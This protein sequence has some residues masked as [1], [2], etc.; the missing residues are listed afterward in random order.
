MKCT[1]ISYVEKFFSDGRESQVL[2]VKSRDP[3]AV[4]CNSKVNGFRFF[5]V[6]EISENGS[7]TF[8]NE[9]S[10]YSKKYYTGERVRV[11]DLV[12][13]GC[14]DFISRIQLSYLT[15]NDLDEAIF[16]INGKCIVDSDGVTLDEVKLENFDNLCGSIFVN[17]TEFFEALATIV[18][19]YKGDIL[20]TAV[21]EEVPVID[22][23]EY[24]LDDYAIVRNFSLFL[25]ENLL[26]SVDG[27][28]NSKKIGCISTDGYSKIGY[29][30]DQ[31]SSMYQEHPYLRPIIS[32]LELDVFDTMDGDNIKSRML[33]IA[34]KFNSNL[35]DDVDEMSSVS[36]LQLVKE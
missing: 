20:Y 18:S 6:D 31:V 13:L 19:R 12:S 1:K 8:V 2:K 27:I 25:D 35:F 9:P 15:N 36:A 33:S 28:V 26:V 7:V 14:N 4:E 16:D 22:D 5:D 32:K 17:Q 23:C 10:N 30:I 24:E 11:S 29:L 21:E 3:F 34:K